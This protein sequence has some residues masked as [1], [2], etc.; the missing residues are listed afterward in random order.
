MLQRH[1][2]IYLQPGT[3]FFLVSSHE[4]NR[5]IKEHASAWF[6]KGL[7][8]IY[9]KQLPNDKFINLG[10]SLWYAN[11]KHRVGVRVNPSAVQKNNPPPQLLAMQDF[12]FRYYAIDNLNSVIELYG[13]TDVAVYGSFLSQYLSGY[14]FVTENSDLDLLINYHEY[15]LNHLQDFVDA[16]TQKFKRVIDGEIR[17]QGLGDISIKELLN[18]STK[19]LLCKSKDKVVLLSR[20]ELYEHYFLL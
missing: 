8:C 15:S 9:A 13:I 14:D 11:K 10:L 5:L 7:P 1:H 4:E 2:L 18:T 19:K 17:F 6:A 3:E 16:L 20:T 12:F